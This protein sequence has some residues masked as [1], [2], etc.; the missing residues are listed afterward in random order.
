MRRSVSHSASIVA[1]LL[2]CAAAGRGAGDDPAASAAAAMGRGDF[3][4]AERTLRTALRS[5]P[6]DARILSLL[7]VA[8]DSQKKSG[9][10]DEFHRRA[11]A[12]APR[13]AD[14]L[15]NYGNHL[16]GAGDEKG[17]RDAYLK[18]AAIDP[19]HSNANL[20]LA[21]LA[22]NRADGAEALTYLKRLPA[23]QQEAP[24][25]AMLKLQALYLAGDRSEA[26]A[27][28]GRLSA[29]AG[30]D[31]GLNLALGVALGSAGQFDKAHG[32]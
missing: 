2:L 10:A 30:S 31:P 1:A 16:L 20:Q 19:A 7:G 3:A 5:L 14:V 23:S 4:S 8:L 24:N 29:R 13:S 15:S 25:A 11:V 17:A 18:A 6:N 12:A 21:R 26:E 32:C 27:L 9:E 22:L 28:A